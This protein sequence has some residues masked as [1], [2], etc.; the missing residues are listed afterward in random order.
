LNDLSAN[1]VRRL[2]SAVKNSVGHNDIEASV[3][4]VMDIMVDNQLKLGE[5]NLHDLETI[6]ATKVDARGVEVQ[7]QLDPSGQIMMRA[8]KD[9]RSLKREALEEEIGKAIDRMGSAREIVREDAENAYVGL[10]FALQ[11]AERIAD[12]KH[13]EKVLRDELK[14]KHDETSEADRRSDAYKDYKKATEDAI[15]QNKIERAQ[16]YFDL[17]GGLTDSLRESIANARA[18]KEAEKQRIREIQHKANSDMEGRE[19]RGQRADSRLDRW[20]EK[21]LLRIAMLPLGSFDQ[22][23]RLFGRKNA[24]GKGYLYD[25]FVRNFIDSADREQ[26]MKEKYEGMLQAKVKELFGTHKAAWSGGLK[27]VPYT[28][29]ALYGY[30]DALPMSKVTYYDGAEM[31]EY[32]LSQAQLGYLYAVEKMPMGRA[33]NRRMG[34]TDEVME[35]IE[36]FL[37]PKLK[38]LIDWMQED[39]LVELGKECNEVHK[40]MFG[41]NMADI[42][43]YFPFVRDKNAI[44]REVVNGSGESMAERIST[45][46]GA[47]IK[48]TPSVAPW[49]LPNANVLDVLAKHVSEMC[50]W[51]SYAELNR[52]LGTLQSYNRFMQQVL[53]MRTIYGGG[54]A[55]WKRFMQSCAMVGNAYEPKRG[56]ADKLMVRGAKGVTIGKIAFRPFTAMKQMLSLPAFFGEVD[57]KTLSDDFDTGGIDSVKWAWENMPN[58]RKRIKSRTVGDFRLSATEYDKEEGWTNRLMRIAAYGMMPNIGVDAW[59]IALG[60]HAVYVKAKKKYLRMGYSEEKAE[61]RAIQDAELC[62]NKSQ[63]SSEGAFMAPVQMSHTF[64]ETT[65]ML[66]RNSST[67][68]TREFVTSVRNLKRMMNGEVDV[69]FMAKQI[70]R[71]AEIPTYSMRFDAELQRQVDGSLPVG[72]VYS[73]GMPGGILQ[74]A[75]FPDSPIELSATRLAEK[76]NDA[77]HPFPI[78]A[79]KGL[80]EAMNKPIAVFR[81][82]NNAMNVIVGL[83]YKGKQFLVGVHFNQHRGG[84]EVS[85]V[86]GLFPKD[87][88]EWLNWISQGKATYLDRQKIKALIAQQRINLADVEYL[89]LKHVANVIKN[90]INPAIPEQ[91][92][93]AGWR[94]EDVERA[95]AQARREY[96]SAY[97]RNSV[98][99]VIFG[100]ILPWLWRIGG[101]SILL[102]LGSDDDEKE[103][104]VEKAT[105]QS[106]FGPLEGL[107]YGDVIGDAMYVTGNNLLGDGSEEYKN[108]GRT[109]PFLSDLNG[110]LRNMDKDKMAAINDVLNMLVGM[111]TGVNLQT[112]SDW[113]TAILDYSP[114]GGTTRE[115]SL[116]VARLLNSPQ[117]QLDKI[118]FDE[119]GMTGEEASRLSPKELVERYAAYKVKR[120]HFVTPWVWGDEDLLEKKRKKGVDAIKERMRAM[121]DDAL[122]KLAPDDSYLRELWEPAMEKALEGVSDAQLKKYFEG[123]YAPEV[124]DKSADEIARRLGGTDGYGNSNAS[125]NLIYADKRDYVDLAEDV[126]LQVAKKRA[127]EAGDDERY[128][129]LDKAER[130]LTAIRKGKHTKKVDIAGFGEGNDEDVL[131]RLRERRRKIMEELEVAR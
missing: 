97:I 129:A 62:F 118:Y 69:N 90:F 30:V 130:E 123:D 83:E 79:L 104:E 56:E 5:A 2:L 80:V 70:L 44:K 100:Y 72:H 1:E 125:Y 101:M 66:F 33:T 112:V 28:Y 51:S 16:S 23:M 78:E 14:R 10:L 113:A 84:T 87:N 17:V 8:F 68:Y 119:L 98:N 88:A 58:F 4:K 94:D 13:E 50:Q 75:G 9:G 115:T 19:L 91:K 57:Y 89:D 60:S 18:F 131:K 54:E 61:R 35:Q 111:E 114:D 53:G 93:F 122:I 76:A 45:K 73:L 22:F 36:G 106:L 95:R 103:A 99:A 77:G 65:M 107:G 20:N 63:Q 121:D 7:G 49:D 26:L 40:R 120:E 12:S 32:D 67:S 117:S 39:F 52:D 110:V 85:S 48:R 46:T 15:R 43:H 11:Y 108:L 41:A 38:E 24:D 116:L 82:G 42:E 96:R 3:Q 86:R 109:N 128:K 81:Y 29:T 55:L 71:N 47:I 37:D 25:H 27:K 124:R 127:K 74:S 102:L 105:A 34:V 6:K 126:L 21:K 64:W 31:R 59:T 92:Y